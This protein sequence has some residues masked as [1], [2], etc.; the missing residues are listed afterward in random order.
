VLMRRKAAILACAI[1][2]TVDNFLRCKDFEHVKNSQIPH[3]AKDIDLQASMLIGVT[4]Q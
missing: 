1:P 3:Q 2:P 4:T